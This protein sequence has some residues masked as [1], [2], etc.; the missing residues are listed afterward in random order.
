MGCLKLSASG[1]GLVG[2]ARVSKRLKLQ[3]PNWCGAAYVSVSTLKRFLKGDA[4]EK[5]NFIALCGVIGVNWKEVAVYEADSS[6]LALSS[7]YIERPPVEEDCYNQIVQPG[8]LTRIKAQQQKGK[9]MLLEQINK[10]AESQGYRIVILSMKL[11]DKSDFS[12]LGIFLKW[13]CIN[14]S[15]ELDLP[16]EVDNYW[17]KGAGDKIS[18]TTYFQKYLL[19]S[20]D[21]PLVL[22]LDD[23]DVIFQ[24]P[25]IR[26]DVLALLRF[27]HEKAKTQQIW[28]KLRLVIAHSTEVYIPLNINQSPFNVGMP[29]ELPDF[30]VEQVQKLAQL[31][32]L[33]LDAN[34]VE[35]LMTMVGGSPDLIQQALFHLKNRL[36]VKLEDLLQNA[37]TESG[38]FKHHLHQHLIM[39]KDNPELAQAMKEVVTATTPVELDSIITYKLQSMGLVQLQ[40]NEVT[41]R[42]NLY[43]KYFQNRLE[44]T[45]KV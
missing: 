13:L 17:N 45:L 29:V 43:K 20:V 36:G 15:L 42:C 39:L 28:Q 37:S 35:Q 10:H 19:K 33:N 6:L 2:K 8:S 27:W 9:T 1:I 18:C 7:I 11:A 38:I 16:I 24:H 44:T 22:A 30:N 25:N 41:P 40:G 32:G 3:D 23:I 21:S 12:E 34:Q 4:I 5:G 31:N 14:A 26:E